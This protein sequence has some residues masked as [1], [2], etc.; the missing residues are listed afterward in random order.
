MCVRFG[1]FPRN[2]TYS[3]VVFTFPLFSPFWGP[4]L[5]I[6]RPFWGLVVVGVVP[7]K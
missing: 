4:C 7:P 2:V 6:R 3:N 5:D 1:L